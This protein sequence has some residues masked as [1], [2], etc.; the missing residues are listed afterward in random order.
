MTLQSN[1][2]IHIRD[3]KILAV[4]GTQAHERAAPQEILANISFTYNAALAGQ[5]DALGHA[6]DYAA[7]HSRIMDKVPQ[8]RFYLLEKLA[9]FIL[10]L[11][12]EDG[13]INSADVILE[14]FGALPGAASVAVKMSAERKDHKIIATTRCC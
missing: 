1:A 4:I 11:I 5:S 12:M 10:A 7:I 6:V 9:Q 3:L 2:I 8:T 13:K 14:K